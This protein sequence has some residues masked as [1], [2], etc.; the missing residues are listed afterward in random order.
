MFV[1]NVMDH[2]SGCLLTHLEYK[3]QLHLGET[4][5]LNSKRYK[6]VE[7]TSV[8]N[9]EEDAPSIDSQRIIVQMEKR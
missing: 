7:V 2:Q 3:N 6:I 4:V 5:I 1:Y 9:T 8:L